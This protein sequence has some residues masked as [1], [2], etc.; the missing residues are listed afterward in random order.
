MTIDYYDYYTT[1]TENCMTVSGAPWHGSRRMEERN[2]KIKISF[3]MEIALMS[4]KNE[5][6]EK[7][8]RSRSRLYLMGNSMDI[9]NKKNKNPARRRR[10]GRKKKKRL[11]YCL[12]CEDSK[13]HHTSGENKY[14]Y[15]QSIIYIFPLLLFFCRILLLLLL[16]F[17]LYYIYLLLR[18]WYE[19][20]SVF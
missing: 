4:D 20:P 16:L 11:L 15:E 5:K 12:Y 19:G 2:N 17:S 1:M 9:I 3:D 18:V 8:I 7:F 10:R 13:H 14:H 6:D